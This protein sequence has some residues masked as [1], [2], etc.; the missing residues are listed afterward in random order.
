MYNI[1]QIAAYEPAKLPIIH[2]ELVMERMKLDKIFSEFLHENE[3]MM[4]E[5]VD[6]PIWH[7]YKEKLKH[8]SKVA[9][10]I[11]TTEYYLKK[12]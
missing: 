12:V 7:E 6:T 11:I 3:G 1:P 10:D 5:N 4:G 9:K 8:Y 2:Q